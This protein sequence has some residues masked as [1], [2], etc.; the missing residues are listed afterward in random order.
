MYVVTT[1]TWSPSRATSRSASCFIPVRR[2]QSSP[3]R[4]CARRLHPLLATFRVLV[5][6]GLAFTI[7]AGM[8]HAAF[9]KAHPYVADFY[10]A[11]EKA[12]IGAARRSRSWPASR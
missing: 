5:A 9:A 6:A 7:P 10:T 12:I 8:D 11:E 1:S 2:P 4:S 3:M